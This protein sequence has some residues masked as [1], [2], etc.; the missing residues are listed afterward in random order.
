M[1][2]GVFTYSMQ[3]RKSSSSLPMAPN[4]NSSTSFT[5]DELECFHAHRHVYTFQ[6]IRSLLMC[7]KARCD[8]STC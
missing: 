2:I 8:Y 1:M 4:K 5:T 6:G 3:A 7:Y